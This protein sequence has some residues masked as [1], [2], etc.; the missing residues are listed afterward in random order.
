MR[1]TET[2]ACMYCEQTPQTGA[3]GRPCPESA[4]HLHWT[5][6][7]HED[8]HDQ[9]LTATAQSLRRAALELDQIAAAIDELPVRLQRKIRS[10][11]LHSA[12][13]RNEAERARDTLHVYGLLDV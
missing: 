10:Y 7:M 4:D 6:E 11:P 5:P 9:K 12:T 3:W 13:I 2:N 8:Y 1:S